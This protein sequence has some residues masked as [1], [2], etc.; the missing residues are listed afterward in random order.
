M[1]KRLTPEDEARLQIDASLGVAGWVV[2][3]RDDMNLAAGR[4]VA[5]REFRLAPGHGHTDY[6]LFVDERA[7]G[8]LEAKP[9]GHTLKG[10]EV[11]SGKY[12]AGLPKTLTAPVTPLPF[13]YESTGVETQFTNRLDPQP[14]SRPVF[15]VHRPETM[16]EWLTWR[17]LAAWANDYGVADPGGQPHWLVTTPSSLRCRVGAMPPL[18]K[19]G[20]WPNQVKAITNLEASFAKDRPR[21]LLQM[22]TG[23][24]KTFTAINAIYR[25]I[26]F[27]GARRIVFLVDRTNL[28]EQ[29]ED[30]FAK[31]VTPD[32]RKRFT[33]LYGVQRLTSNTVLDSAKVVITTIQRLY[34]MIRG[35]ADLDPAAEQGSEFNTTGERL[36]R[37]VDVAYNKKVPPEFFDIVVVDECHRSIY[38][39]WRQVLDYFDSFIVGLTATPAK[40]TFGFFNGNLVMEYGHEQAV[41]D[42]VNVD[43]DVYR[44]RTRITGAGSTIEAGPDT[45]VGLRDRETRAMRWEK[46]DENITYGAEELDRGVVSR[47]QIRT[48][49]RTFKERLFTEIFPGR[50]EVPKTLVF[51]KSDSHADDI[52]GVI[53]EE[54]DK[55]NE[56]CQKITYRTTGAAPK[57][58]IQEFRISYNPR[59][60]VTVDMIATGTD[61]KPVE[62]VM[63]MRSVKSRVYFEQMKG[64]GVRVIDNDDLRKVTP[65]ARAK[66][67]FV[68]VDC[69]G[70]CESEMMDTQP[71]DRKPNVSFDALL[72]HVAAGG[73]DGFLLSSLASRLARLDR[74]CGPEERARLATAGVGAAIT[75]I[76]RAILDALDPDRQVEEARKEFGLDPKAA[77]TPDQIK[78]TTERLSKEAVRPLATN[79]PLRKL[80]RELKTQFE[81]VVDDVSRDEVLEAGLS[82]EAR[83]KAED[84][85]KSFEKFLKD[86]KDEIDALRFFYSRPY[87]ERLRF[88]D[89]KALAEAIKAPPRAWTPERL[90]KAYE[91]LD[92][93]RVRGAAPQR[94]LTDVV[95]L[96][97]FALHQEQELVPFADQVRER[98]ELWMAEQ[99]ASGKRFTTEQVHWLEMIRDHVAQSL[100]IDTADFDLSPFAQEGGL[101]KAAQV[102][103]K[104]FR[105]LLTALNE[106]LAA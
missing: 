93:S 69:V 14:R 74:R 57:D 63:F 54:F 75:D 44:I 50:T 72:E 94:L 31:F 36:Q 52:V 79:P 73:T 87:R 2:Q 49:V 64:R 1:G 35:E 42:H 30:E 46:P 47:D 26:K 70:V 21:A 55:G 89:V 105:P 96:V 66:T 13:L 6:L 88:E 98:F 104:G 11:Q 22:A 80:L 24:G 68:I 78:K 9:K 90:W 18:N 101:A 100:E 82:P 97:R 77:P 84:L 103:G 23:S 91:V 95:S 4:G 92:K 102:F 38:S 62:I 5:V 8:A 67:H 45:V 71:L 83:K 28:G 34:S 86:N 29:A 61:I 10:V 65:D 15:N 27:G 99:Q 81:Q 12:S 41:A 51:A 39:L 43:F 25:L 56:F 33:D 53:R 58:L 3:D 19:D 85:V 76:N 32:D 106:A 40:H 17:P 48:L 37:P 16:A 60:A 20:L 7:V 59:I